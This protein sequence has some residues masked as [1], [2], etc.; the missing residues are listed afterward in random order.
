MNI[1]NKVGE[2]PLVDIEI[3]GLEHINI[4]VKLEYYNPTGSVK[5]R[6]AS[7]ILPKL[8]SKNIINKNTT[9]IESSSGNFGIALSTYCKLLGLNFYCVIDPNI[10]STNERIINDLSSKVFKVQKPDSNGGYLLSR[11]ET[12]KELVE[13]VENSYWVNQYASRYNAEAYYM[14]LGNEICNELNEID[15]IFM[16]VSSGGTITGVSRKIKEKFPNCKVIAVDTE[17]SII[18][19]GP[20]KKRYIPGVGSSIVPE[21][22]NDASIDDVI[23]I[24]EYEAVKMCHQLL[25]ENSILAGGSSGLVM[26]AIKKYFMN[27]KTDTPPKVLTIFPDRGER[28]MDTIYNDVWCEK[29]ISEKKQHFV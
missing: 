7:Y 1:L 5:D 6:S 4:K 3:Q 17:G 22:L 14:T 11:I 2:T 12:V 13:T 10:T 18:F 25:K 19:G 9:I 23:I 20:S 24:E 29:L 27:V 15:Y 16:G 21:I 8:L 26:S 28:Y